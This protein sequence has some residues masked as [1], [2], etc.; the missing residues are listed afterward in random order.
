MINFP[1]E[2]NYKKY[3]IIKSIRK[4]GPN[5]PMAL[6]RIVNSSF[7]EKLTYVLGGN[8]VEEKNNPTNHDF[9]V[10]RSNDDSLLAT[11][12]FQHGAISDD[13]VNGVL[14]EDLLMML[15][16]RVES[17]QRSKL[18]CRENENALQ[19]LYEALWWLNQRHNKK[20]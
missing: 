8:N 2:K 4:R 6:E 17:F 1:L 14:N 3:Y 19:H 16:D 13:G 20:K 7:D 15:I 11:I 5:K 18:K 12:H 10:R 9:E